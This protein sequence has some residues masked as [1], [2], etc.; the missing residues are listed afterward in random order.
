MKRLT[1]DIGVRW[2]EDLTLGG[3]SNFS[4]MI[5]KGDEKPVEMRCCCDY[6]K[7]VEYLVRATPYVVLSWIRAFGPS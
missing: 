5:V 1:R 4:V 2:P 6:H 7:H 3:P